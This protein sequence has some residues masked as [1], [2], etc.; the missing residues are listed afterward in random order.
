LSIYQ[1]EIR[2]RVLN[3]TVAHIREEG[4]DGQVLASHLVINIGYRFRRAATTPM[5]VHVT[6]IPARRLRIS[7]LDKKTMPAEQTQDQPKPETNPLFMAFEGIH[8]ISGSDRTLDT[9]SI[10]TSSL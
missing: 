6:R 2:H 7:G 9:T 5:H 3:F 10:R 8:N 1:W 4:Y